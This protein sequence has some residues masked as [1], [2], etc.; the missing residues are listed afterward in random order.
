M[1][2]KIC[3]INPPMASKIN[4][5][6]GILAILGFLSDPQLLNMIPAQYSSKIMII[7]GGLLIVWRSFFTA[8]PVAP[9][10]PNQPAG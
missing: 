9:P 8:C 1:L 2:L 10:D 3:K 7:A 4:W 6:A 5:T